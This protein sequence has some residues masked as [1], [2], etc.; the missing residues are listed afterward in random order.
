MTADRKSENNISTAGNAA[1]V[2]VTNIQNQYVNPAREP[3]SKESKPSFSTVPSPL[4]DD[5]YVGHGTLLQD[6]LASVKTN[7]RVA[8]YGLGGIGKS[9]LAAEVASNLHPEIFDCVFWIDAT[10]VTSFMRSMEYLADKLGLPRKP[11]ATSVANAVRVWM[12]SKG[13]GSWLLVLDAAGL[14]AVSDDIELPVESKEKHFFQR[15]P[16][17]S[18]SPLR[19]ILATT[20][21]K[22]VAQKW[23][24]D[25]TIFEVPCLEKEDAAEL[26]RSESGDRTSP[27]QDAYGLVNELD[28]HPSAILSAAAII[29]SNSEAE[30]TISTYLKTFRKRSDKAINLLDRNF[31]SAH[32]IYISPKS[33]TATIRTA[34][35]MIHQ[36]SKGASALLSFVS[37]LEGTKICS[38]LFRHAFNW[39]EQ[40]LR[41]N[42]SILLNY[43]LLKPFSMPK[44]TPGCYSMPRL[45]RL[46]VRDWIRR[47]ETTNSDL[48]PLLPWHLKALSSL[49]AEYDRMAPKERESTVRAQL[50]QRSLLTHAEVFKQFC[51]RK[52]GDNAPLK[53]H[54]F[55]AIVVFAGLFSSEGLY[56][57]AEVLLG[58]AREC[59]VPDSH[60]RKLALFRLAECLRNQSLVDGNTGR[61]KKATDIVR[62]V[63]QT[64]TYVETLDM[65]STFALLWG[66]RGNFKKAAYYQN[67]VVQALAEALGEGDLQVMD[68]RLV[69]SKIRWQE[70]GFDDALQD[71]LY[72]RD[73]LQ[74]KFSTDPDNGSRLLQ[75]QAALVR[76]YHSL[77]RVNTAT[78]LARQVVRGRAELL[79]DLDM[80]TI[81]S[82]K[83]LA[84]CLRDNGLND[85]AREVLE[86]VKEKLQN[87]FGLNHK[88]VQ[89]CVARLK[90]IQ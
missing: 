36:R 18:I 73:L 81:G 77:N 28:R 75:V 42:V 41:T 38:N 68:A 4:T 82:E 35:N 11:D 67:Q 83:D 6:V 62:E 40:V 13:N 44:G 55:R 20:C 7:T 53:E 57:A 23:C 27:L 52:R 74:R 88:E 5:K 16:Q 17:R 46:T 19:V 78:T 2:G 85:E 86:R 15:L 60:W 80:K 1:N 84:Q 65:W 45:V 56:K 25:D 3:P 89:S 61:L 22:T 69:L 64:V 51:R 30:E 24:K 47:Q 76:T 63:K 79:G 59:V 10:T 9:R 29:R 90:G 50:E 26:L 12:E 37:C 48:E 72:I 87:K 39:S 21:E 58:Y 66:D 71:Q 8:L 34:I 43:R 32:A 31:T 54:H 49:L 33:P 70:G 14:E